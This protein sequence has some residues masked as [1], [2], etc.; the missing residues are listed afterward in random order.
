MFHHTSLNLIVQNNIDVSEKKSKVKM[1][2]EPMLEVLA[3][4]EP[5]EPKP[6]PKPEVRI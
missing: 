1:K 6:Q 3:Q 4:G 2:N 5:E